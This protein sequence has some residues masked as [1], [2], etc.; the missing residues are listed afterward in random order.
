[1]PKSGVSAKNICVRGVSP[2]VFDML[3]GVTLCLLLSVGRNYAEGVRE[4]VAKQ[5]RTQEFCSGVGGV[6]PTNSV[7]DR[8]NWE[9]GAV[10]P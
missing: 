9:Q 10:A 7:E 1:V 3:K 6:V 4:Q 5:W 2:D 8:E